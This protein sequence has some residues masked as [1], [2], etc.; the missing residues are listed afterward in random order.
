VAAVAT[1]TAL[2]P[3]A[4]PTLSPI[5]RPELL[6]AVL[7]RHHGSRTAD[8]VAIVGLD[9]Y[10]RARATF[11]PRAL[12]DV[13]RASPVLQ[14]EARV[15]GG[16]VYYVDGL[17]VVRRLAPRGGEPRT[18]ATFPITSD[19]Q[20]VAFAVSPDGTRLM[21]TVL[22]VTPVVGA[23][24]TAGLPPWHV[25][26]EVAGAGGPTVTVRS[27]DIPATEPGTAPRAL[28]MVGW[29]RTGAVA[30]P[31]GVGAEQ[32]DESGGL[33]QGHPAHVDS[34]GLAGPPLGG[35][36]CGASYEEPDGNLLCADL[37]GATTTLRRPD[38]STIHR[39]DN[40]G[41][42]PHLSADGGHLAYSGAGGGPSAVQSREGNTVSLATGFTPSGW[43]DGGL[44]IGN[45]RGEELGYLALSAPGRTEDIGF[46]GT[47]VGVVQ[48]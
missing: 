45:T 24:A 37:P 2:A 1:P 9:G 5:P 47:F 46:P 29:D 28:Q 3:S 25:D 6:V 18:V 42:G 21:A 43:L 41:A 7:E 15:V 19:R 34:H 17:G 26:V 30:L 36:T 13:G 23:E 44:L 20:S 12:P 16:A 48:G 10:A 38:G 39:F 35:P 14:P 32:E 4:R 11:Q 33:W 40:T 27:I 31:D 8:T 22:T